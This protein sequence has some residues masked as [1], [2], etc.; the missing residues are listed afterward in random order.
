MKL[1]DSYQ[2]I[3][4]RSMLASDATMAAGLHEK[5]AFLAYHAFESIGSAL[6]VHAGRTAGPKVPHPSKLHQFRRAAEPYGW[7]KPVANLVVTLGN[8]RNS[9]LYPAEAA[10]NDYDPPEAV[11]TTAQAADVRRRVAGAVKLV[12]SVLP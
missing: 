7:G 5:S 3:A 11:V 1:V 2:R 9:C 12:D 4:H 10:P 8:L 6:A